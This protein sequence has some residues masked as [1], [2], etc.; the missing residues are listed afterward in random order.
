MADAPEWARIAGE[1][2]SFITGV[3]IAYEDLEGEW[4]EGFEAGPTENPEDEDVAMDPDEDLPW[5]DPKRIETWWKA[6]AGRFA[7][8]TRYLVGAPISETQCQQVLRTGMQRQRTAAAL[9]LALMYPAA[10]LFETRAPGFRQQQLLVG[11]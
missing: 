6:N 1:A 4:P 7:S 9:E 8:G 10:P 5:P 2:L 11:S 3:E